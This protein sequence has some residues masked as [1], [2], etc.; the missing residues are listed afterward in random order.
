[1]RNSPD[2]ATPVDVC[3]RT[4][5][6]LL[7]LGVRHICICNL[8]MHDAA[9]VLAAIMEKVNSHDVKAL[10]VGRW[11]ELLE[12]PSPIDSDRFARHE[13]AVNQGE[14]RFGNLGFSTPTAQR[15][16]ALDGGELFV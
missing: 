10:G 3:A 11:R 12:M 15:R 8:P 13:V 2:G 16:D 1:M 4:I 6:A 7:S 5:R 9:Q 14:H